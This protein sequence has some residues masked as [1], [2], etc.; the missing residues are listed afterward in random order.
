VAGCVPGVVHTAVAIDIPADE[1]RHGYLQDR[2]R[3]AWARLPGW[4]GIH[5]CPGDSGSLNV[6]R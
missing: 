3:N 1:D 6:K 2:D 5:D 4:A